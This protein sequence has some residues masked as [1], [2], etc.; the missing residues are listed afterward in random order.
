[1]CSLNLK[2]QYSNNIKSLLK[3]VKEASFYDSTNLFKIGEET[4]KKASQRESNKGAVAEVYLYYGSYFYYTRNIFRSKY[5]LS[6]S[7]KEA[8]KTNNSHIKTLSNIRLLFMEHEGGLNPN[9]E[10]EFKNLLT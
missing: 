10:E 5:Y 1:M 4:I 8:E 9:V 2:S 7:I 3:T 6:K